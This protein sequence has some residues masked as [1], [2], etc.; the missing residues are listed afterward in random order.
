MQVERLSISLPETVCYF[1]DEYQKSHALKS[2]SSV[3][4]AAIKLLQQ[5]E[6]EQDYREA[7]SEV[8]P[9][10]ENTVSDGLDETW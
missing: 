6:L 3:I 1:L 7:S 8:D 4:L 2:R 9:L 5:K 10:W